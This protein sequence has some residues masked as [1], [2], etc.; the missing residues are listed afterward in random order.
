MNFTQRM[1]GIVKTIAV[2]LS[3][4]VPVML[5]VSAADARIG[6]GGSSGSRGSR[7][8]S[9]PPSTSTAPNAAQPFNRTMTQPGSPGMGTA[10]AGGAAKGG[11]FNRPGMGMLGGLAAGFLGAG[12]LGMLFGGGMFGG[13]GGLS[14]IFGLILQIGLIIIVVKLAMNWWQR[15]NATA[16]AYA[17]PS[18]TGP[19]AATGPLAS[20]RSGSGFG[21]GSGSAP[22]E[23]GPSDYEAFE[24]LLGEIQAA[25]SNEDV[26]KLHTLATPEMVS[27]FTQ[28]LQANSA[29]GDVNKV[30]DVK[31]LQGDLAEAWREGDTDYASVAMRFSLVDKTIE[32]STGRLVEGSEQP[33]EATEVWTFV[34]PR[35]ANWELSAIQQA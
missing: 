18:G 17:G 16:S 22:L 12:L 28:D 2:V 9:A 23:I 33:T 26:A 14:S 24:R 10:V 13:L 5:T 8:F 34:R 21:L 11:F 20:F 32:R 29:R 1:R 27:Y 15:R 30:S 35:G 3:L 7:T 25:W 4:A 19:T 31:L 6:G